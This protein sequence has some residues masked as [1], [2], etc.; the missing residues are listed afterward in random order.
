M[1]LKV[2]KHQEESSNVINDDGGVDKLY[3]AAAE[4]NIRL[5]LSLNYT[6]RF[7]IMMRLMRIDKMFSQAKITHKKMP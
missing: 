4:R 5:A 3:K 6:E 1:G 2:D 7:K